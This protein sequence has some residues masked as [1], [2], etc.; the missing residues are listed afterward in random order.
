MSRFISLFLFFTFACTGIASASNLSKPYAWA[1]QSAKQDASPH[2]IKKVI[3]RAHTLLGTPYRWGGMS[4]D[5]GFDCSGMLVYLFKNEANIHVP[6]TT[7]AMLNA[8]LPKVARHKLK[9]G[10]AV[11]FSTQGGTRSNHVGLYIG[12]NRFIH[13]PRKG[14]TVR[15][16]SLDNS[17]WNKNYTTARR[18]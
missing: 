18:F 12:D 8:D 14:K 17:Y 2:H 4:L 6:R 3:N 7:S 1:I 13:A 11:F 5:E 9:P 15:I 10:D 16:D